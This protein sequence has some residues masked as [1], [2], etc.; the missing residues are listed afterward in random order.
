MARQSLWLSN[1]IFG[2][3]SP[4]LCYWLFIPSH[5]VGICD[6]GPSSSQRDRTKSQFILYC[7]PERKLEEYRKHLPDLDLEVVRRNYPV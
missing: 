5:Q 1:S 6:L 7:P 2:K 4:R 3:S